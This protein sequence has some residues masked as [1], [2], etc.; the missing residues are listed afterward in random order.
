[1][2]GRPALL[3][4]SNPYEQHSADEYFQGRSEE[5]KRQAGEA[6]ARR[7]TTLLGRTGRV[8]ELGCGTGVLLEG[9]QA[10]GW[11]VRGVEMTACFAD[12]ARARGLDVELAS[13]ES[14]RSLDEH[15]DV[16]LL[17]AVLEHLYEPKPCLARVFD[18]LV[19][20][21]LTFIDVPN[22][23]SLWSRVGNA[24]MRLRGR[25]WAVNLSPTFPPY[26]VVGFCP[27]SLRFLSRSVGFDVIEIQTLRWRNELPASK[28]WI[29][30]I[31]RAGA[32]LAMT[33]GVWLGAGVGITA[34]L[35]RPPA[36]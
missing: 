35:R 8:L 7:A 3:P 34:W 25:D 9:M 29:G 2:Y 21:G 18:A 14:C 33:V 5:A 32:D 13:V 6:L 11:L 10:S 15:W 16:V 22:E 30:E 12:D 31:E 26:H 28:S 23:C 1:M 17:A 19:P 4:A 27:R 24:Y 36:S 20:G